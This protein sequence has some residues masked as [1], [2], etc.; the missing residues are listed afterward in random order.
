MI[1]KTKLV[2]GCL[3]LFLHSPLLISLHE[4]KDKISIQSTSFFISHFFPQNRFE[5]ISSSFANHLSLFLRMVTYSIVTLVWWAHQ[6]TKNF[7]NRMMWSWANWIPLW[8]PKE[9]ILYSGISGTRTLLQ[10]NP[11]TLPEK[12]QVLFLPWKWTTGRMS[13]ATPL[14][15]WYDISF[16][17]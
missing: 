7:C 2:S 5:L 12:T 17:N 16:W 13:N 14:W 4:I 8:T 15:T 6:P 3:D 11:S 1:F 10:A 9:G